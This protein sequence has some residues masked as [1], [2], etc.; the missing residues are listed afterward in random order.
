M[1]QVVEP[2]SCFLRNGHLNKSP[3]Q[4]PQRLHSPRRSESASI[5]SSL[6]KRM[7]T[8]RRNL[9]CACLARSFASSTARARFCASRSSNE[10][11]LLL[12]LRAWP[13]RLLEV[14][15]IARNRRR[16]QRRFGR[17]RGPREVWV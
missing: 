5:T 9:P 1:P 8:K 16:D 13:A 6:R 3:Q 11:R 2:S 7:L 15:F 10:R 17:R 14:C 4:A 12:L